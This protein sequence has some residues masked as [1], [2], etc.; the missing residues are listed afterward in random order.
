M[1]GVWGKDGL[2]LE[3]KIFTEAVEINLELAG[4]ELADI[5]SKFDGLKF[6]PEK[7]FIKLNLY[8][9]LLVIFSLTPDYFLLMVTDSTVIHGKLNFYFNTYKKDLVAAL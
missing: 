7:Y 2:E 1:M 8:G 5:I 3:K 4:A 6:P 9:Y